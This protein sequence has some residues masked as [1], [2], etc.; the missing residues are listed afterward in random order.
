M[1]Q[2]VLVTRPEPHCDYLVNALESKGYFAYAFPTLEI[3]KRDLIVSP[4]DKTLN[5]HNTYLI[6]TSQHALRKA[7]FEWIA[8]FKSWVEEGCLQVIALGNATAS[9]AVAF[10]LGV[11]WVA[12]TGGDSEWVLAIPELAALVG[13]KIYL[14]TGAGGR[15]LLQETCVA[16]GAAVEVLEVYERVCPKMKLHPFKMLAQKIQIISVTS[17]QGAKNLFQLVPYGYHSWLIACRWIVPSMRIK[18]SLLALFPLLERGII[19]SKG[20]GNKAIIEAL[21]AGGI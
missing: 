1:A 18:N 20:A 8:T 2:G 11:Q 4:L 15:T 19:V 13:A 7:P 12:P 14:L 16:R 3:V 6:V 17:L 9:E 21:E 10:G 5:P